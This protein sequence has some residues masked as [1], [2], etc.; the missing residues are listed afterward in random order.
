LRSEHLFGK[1]KEYRTKRLKES[2]NDRNFFRLNKK[3]ED[4]ISVVFNVYSS[5]LLVCQMK[6]AWVYPLINRV[7]TLKIY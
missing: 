1:L 2:R 6:L 4:L 3:P 5:L 7:I